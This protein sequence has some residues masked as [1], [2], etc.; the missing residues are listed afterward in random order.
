MSH[1][2]HKFI[3]RVK[4]TREAFICVRETALWRDLT[5]AYLRLR[6]LKYPYELRL[7][8]WR[9]HYSAGAHRGS[10]MAVFSI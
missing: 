5:L 8:F 10:G 1:A 6:P 9:T 7:S 4:Q 3:T 2:L